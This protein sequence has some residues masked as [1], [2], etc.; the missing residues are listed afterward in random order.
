[1]DSITT[2]RRIAIGYAL[3]GG[4]AKTFAELGALKALEE[5]GIFPSYISG[6]S[7][8]ATI[9]ALYAMGYRADELIDIFSH[10]K[11]QKLFVLTFR[12]IV[13]PVENYPEGAFIKR[14]AGNK[15]LT[16]RIELLPTPFSVNVTKRK[17]TKSIVL[18]KGSLDEAVMASNAA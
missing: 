6:T 8:G 11:R 15:G 17:P 10:T 5:V 16:N 9:G 14:L 4:G 1:M 18:L 2:K 12:D 13:G 7:M 3:G